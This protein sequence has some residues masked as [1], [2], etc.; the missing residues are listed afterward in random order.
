MGDYSD[1]VLEGYLCA[2]CTAYTG[3]DCGHETLCNDCLRKLKSQKSV[4]K[5]ED[6]KI[7]KSSSFF[8]VIFGIIMNSVLSIMSKFG[9][10]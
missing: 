2:N 7:K 1:M 9:K 8:E 5:K 10:K 3:K 6:L 4:F